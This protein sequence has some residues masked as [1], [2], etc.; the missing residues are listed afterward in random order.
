MLTK[1]YKLGS[2]YKNDSRQSFTDFTMTATDM[3]II[4]Y[5]LI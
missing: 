3:D 1:I 5:N 4:N 2:N